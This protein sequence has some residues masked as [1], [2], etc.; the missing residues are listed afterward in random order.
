MRILRAEL[1][2]KFIKKHRNVS[3][4][5]R[6]WYDEVTA[7]QWQKPDDA[8]IQYPR[9]SIVGNDRIV[10][11]VRGNNYRIVCRVSYA[12]QIIEI[13]FVGTHAD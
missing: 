6:A 4:Y 8:K 2:W 3:S 10:F 11:R 5:L 1:L 9:C 13:R 12:L 7:A